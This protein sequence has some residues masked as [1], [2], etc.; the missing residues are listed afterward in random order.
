VAPEKHL[1]SK[2]PK[3]AYFVSSHGFGHAA[4]TRT[5]LQQ[6]QSCA[7]VTVFS[8]TPAWFWGDVK[9]DHI[10]YQA[11]VGCIQQGTLS[12]DEDATS[13][14][15]R[16]FLADSHKRFTWFSGICSQNPFDLIV[17]DIA[18]EPLEFAHR[19]GIPS[20][21]IANFTWVEIYNQ[22]P[23][24]SDLIPTV[25]QQ[26]QMADRTYIP[27][28]QTGMTWADNTII[29]DPVAEI[30]TCIRSTLDPDNLYS[31]SVYIDA[32]RWGTEIGWGNAS[33]F[34]DTL[35]IR[36]GHFL[37]GL[38]SNVRQLAFGAVKHADLISSVDL[39][40]SKPGYGIVTECLANQAHWC[41]IPRDGFAEDEVLIEGAE[42]FGR[43][44]MA[45]PKQLATLSFECVDEQN[46]KS[47]M[48][49][50]GASQISNNL[51]L[52]I[53]D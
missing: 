44:S 4:R 28:F 13:D 45:D 41:C 24:L 8:T 17:T 38:P 19:L 49:F 9:V 14:A 52:Q 25:L 1:L 12:I 7:E 32:G 23:L 48:T 22:M 11:D 46:G 42:K 2:R 30:G 16:R 20:A 15:F 34:S 53:S 31:R 43:Y 6:L 5:I 3:V 39:V 37:D 50:D 18:P 33:S 26:Y 35:F 21:L 40:V 10:H 47:R 27:G 36:V 29:V 51:I